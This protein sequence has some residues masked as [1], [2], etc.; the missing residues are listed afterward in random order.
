MALSELCGMSDFDSYKMNEIYDNDLN[1]LCN[2]F[3]S[4]VQL[5]IPPFSTVSG[6]KISLNK[7][8]LKLFSS[9]VRRQFNEIPKR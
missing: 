7:L 5:A 3:V 2:N 9:V 6:R 8:I 4:S 1:K